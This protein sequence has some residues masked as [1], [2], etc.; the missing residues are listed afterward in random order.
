MLT[1]S[2]RRFLTIGGFLIAL[3]F[4]AGGCELECQSDGVVEDTVDEIGDEVED[5]A[6]ELDDQP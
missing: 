6:E 3:S 4:T 1:G 2:I 5:V